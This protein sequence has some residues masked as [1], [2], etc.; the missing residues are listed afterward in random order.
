MLRLSLA[1]VGSQDFDRGVDA[2]RHRST[3]HFQLVVLILLL[4]ACATVLSGCGMGKI[5]TTVSSQPIPVLGPAMQGRVHGGNQPVSGA[6]IQLY[7]AGLNGYGSAPTSLLTSTVTTDGAESFGITGKYPCPDADSDGD[8]QVYLV[9]TGG[10]PGL[11]G[12]VNNSALVLMAALGSCNQLIAGGASIFIDVN[13]VS[14][15]AAAY[16]LAQ[17]AV[18]DPSAPGILVGT[19]GSNINGLNSA[20][21][22]VNNLVDLPT[23]TALSITPYYKA[24]GGTSGGLL[25]SSYVPQARINTLADALAPCVNSTG[26]D[27]AC[28]AL[29]NAAKAP[30]GF[31]P[32]DTLQAILSIAQHPGNNPAGIWGLPSSTPPFEPTLSSAP[33]DFAL[34]LTYT[35]GGMGVD[36]TD[37]VDIDQ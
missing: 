2:S 19:S 18:P 17:F 7:A 9:A 26:T 6:T 20:M 25:N 12:N 13:E 24:L 28:T 36:P 14:T 4:L 21:K 5:D 34:A 23:G 27:G 10:N 35:G 33:N 8:S 22:T 11:P 3:V 31:T 29:F 16:S 30:G 32:T 15:V 1:Q 37:P